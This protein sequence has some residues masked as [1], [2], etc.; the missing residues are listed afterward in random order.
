MEAVLLFNKL[1]CGVLM[2]IT[3]LV[4][5][6]HRYSASFRH[7]LPV[8]ISHTILLGLFGFAVLNVSWPALIALFIAYVFSGYGLWVVYKS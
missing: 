3:A 2:A 5:Y 4:A 1:V 8:A 6:E 7:I